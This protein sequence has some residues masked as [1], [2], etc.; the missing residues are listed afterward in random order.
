MY[1]STTV[2]SIKLVII[3]MYSL[4]P[5]LQLIYDQFLEARTQV[6]HYHHSGRD[7]RREV[8]VLAELSVKVNSATKLSKKCVEKSL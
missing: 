4:L 1:T 8:V 3:S 6:E 5:G 7:L 2:L